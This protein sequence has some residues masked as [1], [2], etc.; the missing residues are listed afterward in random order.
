MTKRKANI[1]E[2]QK[3][4]TSAE[5]GVVDFRP[6][7]AVT[8]RECGCSFQEIADTMG[9]S[10]QMALTMVQKAKAKL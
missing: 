2:I 4:L 3:L 7:I 9:F 6:V 8:M 5:D 1:E 10:R